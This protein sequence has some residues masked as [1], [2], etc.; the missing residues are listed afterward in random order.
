MAGFT[1]P[2]RLKSLLARRVYRYPSKPGG[3]ALDEISMMGW[4]GC[5]RIL[6]STLQSMAD[7]WIPLCPRFESSATTVFSSI[8]SRLVKEAKSKPSPQEVFSFH[9]HITRMD[10]D[11]KICE[12]IEIHLMRPRQ[13]I[14][15]FD[16][17]GVLRQMYITRSGLL[18][19]NILVHTYWP[20]S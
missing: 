10:G 18:F 20:S 2:F 17:S 16:F 19:S 8:L 15:F 1:C 5:E 11:V 14:M 13:K 6:H 9:V 4:G 7:F 3:V 12:K